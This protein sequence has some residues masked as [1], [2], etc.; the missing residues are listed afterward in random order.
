MANRF[1]QQ[2]NEAQ[3]LTKAAVIGSPATIARKLALI[4]RGAGLDGVTV[5]VPDFIDDLA[6]IGTQVVA[7]LAREGVI[8]NA[9]LIAAQRGHR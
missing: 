6:V 3:A 1:I 5:I 2:G 9:A 4:V 7:G 8:T